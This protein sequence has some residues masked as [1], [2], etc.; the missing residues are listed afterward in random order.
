MFLS[1]RSPSTLNYNVK[2]SV[3]AV[4]WNETDTQQYSDQLDFA[5]ST[6]ALLC[7]GMFEQQYLLSYALLN[8]E[9]L[10]HDLLSF[11][12]FRVDY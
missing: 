11:G 7:V 2:C 10:G 12:L 6:F 9:L 5:D 4:D 1:V 8:F 3:P